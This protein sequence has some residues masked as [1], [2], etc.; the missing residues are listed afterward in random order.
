[1]PAPSVRAFSLLLGASLLSPAAC[2]R[3]AP[4]LPNLR[5]AA[6]ADLAFAL[7]EVARLYEADTGRH[8][9]LIFGSTGLLAR[10]LAE[11]APFDLFAAADEAFADQA[12]K[13]GACDAAS[14]RLYARGRIV[15]W[16][17]K[18]KARP[19]SLA[20]L[21]DGRFKKIA[22]ANPEHAPYGRAALQALG[23]AGVLAA[24]R[25][26]L[27]YGENVQQALQYARTGNADAALVALSLA[28]PAADGDALPIDPALHDPI[29]QAL[30]VCK[31]G[32]AAEA[33]GKL[34]ELI[35][36]ARGRALFRRH[37]L[38]LPGEAQDGAPA[39]TAAPGPA[40]GSTALD[41]G[42]R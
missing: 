10:Q 33:A 23:R 30:I 2:R 15:A 19:A 39:S 34:A 9:D 22:I 21:A 5:V 28:L 24:V 37:G 3:E 6:A 14:K 31:N 18:G 41:A 20:D 32:Q 25:P 11:G 13:S 26:K 29:D 1:M 17:L 16:T 38:L 12:A 7:P 35:G 40:D 36:S 4:A 8:V 42:G 27:V